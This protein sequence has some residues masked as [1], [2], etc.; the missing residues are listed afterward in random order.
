MQAVRVRK[1]KIAANRLQRAGFFSE[2]NFQTLE[3]KF[4]MIKTALRRVE[5]CPG[6]C[7]A[8]VFVGGAM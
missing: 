7:E 1:Q 4:G 3:R 2:W 8:A 6:E 5:G